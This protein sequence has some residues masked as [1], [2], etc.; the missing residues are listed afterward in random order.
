VDLDRTDRKHLAELIANHQWNPSQKAPAT[1]W[2]AE[3]DRLMQAQ[4]ATTDQQTQSNIDRLQQI[5]WEQEPFY[6]WS[7]KT[8]RRDRR[9]CAHGK[10]VVLYPRLIERRSNPVDGR[11]ARLFRERTAQLSISPAIPAPTS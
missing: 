4:A 11:M 3:I 7:Q 10:A 6:T 2:E 5:V 9:E 1:D 8:R